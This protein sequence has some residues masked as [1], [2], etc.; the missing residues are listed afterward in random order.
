M[1]YTILLDNL[2]FVSPVGVYAEEKKNANRIV[3]DIK[4]HVITS[5]AHV[6]DSLSDTVDY[7]SVYQEVSTVMAQEG[8]LLEAKAWQIGTRILALSE[9]IHATEVA[10]CKK[11]PPKM[12]SAKGAG[13]Y[14]FLNRNNAF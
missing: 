3:V 2:E 7:V 10:I 12:P 6:S 5:Q 14:F 8:N 4:I 11:N 9:K 13:V 1:N